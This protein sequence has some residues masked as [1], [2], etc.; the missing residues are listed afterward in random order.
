MA[1]NLRILIVDDDRRMVKTLVD[2]LHL[3][4]YHAQGAHTS[5]NALEMVEEDDFDCVLTDIRM[6]DMNGVDLFRKIKKIRSDLPVVFMTAYATDKLFREALEEGA[7]AT[8][9][10]PLDINLL[11]N[12]FS[13]LG[14]EPSIV[15]VD[16]DSMFCQTIGDILNS[17]GFEVTQVTDHSLLREILR[18][19]GQIVL[20]DMKLKDVS[21]LH[22]LRKIRERYPDLP[23]V[24]ITGYKSDMSSSIDAALQINAFTCLYKPL[25]IEN[26]L[27][28]LTRIHYRELGRILDKSTSSKEE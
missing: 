17:R 4:G 2:I 27:Q 14:E 10:K 3:K 18:P 5:K 22:I 8:L 16:D 19:Q 25:E 9:N 6:P 21:G 24:L 28:V 15:I 13:A 12:F 7:I 26:L 23:V 20:L 1:A 11:L